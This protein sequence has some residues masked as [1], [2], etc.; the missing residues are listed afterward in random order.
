MAVCS[1]CG[2]SYQAGDTRGVCPYCN[3][4]RLRSQQSGVSV[5]NASFWAL[6][7]PFLGGVALALLVD[8]ELGFSVWALGTFLGLYI[9]SICWAGADAHARGKPGWLVALLVAFSFWWGLLLWIIF[10]PD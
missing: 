5:G 2:G 7:T 6:G 9:W 10:R 8:A 4:Y 3:A 1:A